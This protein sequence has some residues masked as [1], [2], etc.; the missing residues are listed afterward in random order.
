MAEPL[1]VTAIWDAE[2]KVWIA[3]SRGVAM[4]GFF[5]YLGYSAAVLLPLFAVI[6]WIYS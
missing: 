5:A 6:S 3:E 2:A 1:V 4:P